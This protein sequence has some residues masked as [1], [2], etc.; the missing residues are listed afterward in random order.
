MQDRR[1][2]ILKAAIGIL[3]EEG[4]SGLTQPRVAKLADVRQ[5]HLTYYF[6]TRLA[7]LEGVARVAVDGQLAALDSLLDKSSIEAL[8]ATIAR[9]VVN[10]ES[11]RVL[12]ALAHAADQEPTVRALFREL[13]EGVVARA[14][15]ALRTIDPDI[16]GEHIQLLHAL[17]IG[18]A[19]LDL[20]T[21]RPDGIAH[22][23]AMTSALLGFIAPTAKKV[24]RASGAKQTKSN[25]NSGEL[26]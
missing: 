4:Y 17:S 3:R 12:M 23:T 5:S 2:D 9:L 19:V 16:K 20:A 8:T 15:T 21:G 6:P 1:Q 25:I 14:G 24:K 18:V 13:A 22:A 10:H 11:T 7:L 26:T